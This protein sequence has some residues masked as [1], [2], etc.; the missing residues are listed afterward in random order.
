MRKVHLDIVSLMLATDEADHLTKF[1]HNGMDSARVKRVLKKPCE[2][3]GDSRCCAQQL[4]V[5]G[6]VEYGQRSHHL[7]AECRGH[8][9]A[10]SYETCGPVPTDKAIRT[11]WHLLGV[12]VDVVALAVILGLTPRTLYKSVHQA[13]DLRKGPWSVQP[14]AAPQQCMVDLFFAELYMSAA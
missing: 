3:T 9:V 14:H 7:S 1:A 12:P 13:V 4:S 11:Q 8:L 2:C 5:A 10:T 6:V